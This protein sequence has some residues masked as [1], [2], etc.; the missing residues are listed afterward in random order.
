MPSK[1]AKNPALIFAF[2]FGIVSSLLLGV[3]MCL[4]MGILTAVTP[5]TM[6]LG[7]AVGCVGI[8][9]AC[10][11][12]PLYKKILAKSKAKYAA[13]I[14]KLAHEIAEEA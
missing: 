3:G 7:V 14:L 9:G 10:V 2:T 11:N 8:A 5:L 4:T 1:K 12:Y 6:G 13:D